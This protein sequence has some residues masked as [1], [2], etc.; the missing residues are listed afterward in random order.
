MEILVRFEVS[1]AVTMKNG[2][3][4]TQKTPFFMEIL[5]FFGLIFKKFAVY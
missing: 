2:G 4:T 3:V 1:A 5:I